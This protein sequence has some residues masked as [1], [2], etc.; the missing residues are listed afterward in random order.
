MKMNTSLA[1]AALASVIG[2][3]ALAQTD[4]FANTG[5]GTGKSAVEERNEDLADDIEDDF[6]RNVDRFGNEG[7]RLGF[8]GSLS[9][10]GLATDGNDRDYNLGIGANLGYFDGVNG[11]ELNLSYA[12]SRGEYKNEA[13]EDELQTS[14]DNLLYEF[15][16]TRDFNPDLYGFVKLQGSYNGDDEGG[17]DFVDADGDGINDNEDEAY[18]RNDV[19]LGLGIGYRIINTP[20]QQ[21]A[22]Q[23]GPGYR[24]S[25]FG[26]IDN[27]IL[28][29]DILEG[30][31]DDI[32]EAAFG[33]SSN[34]FQRINDTV[35]FTIDTDIIT[36]SADT[37]VYNDAGLN[38]AMSNRLALRTSLQTEYHTDPI[39]SRDS[40]DNRLGV[41]VVYNFN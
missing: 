3:A 18:R 33:V 35:F 19:F 30:D 4:T 17:S 41:A 31:G 36:S 25:D 37:V 20:D 39:G 22:I 2:T 34:Y 14:Q 9:A 12:F 28:S 26:N 40:T 16:Y 7:R 5:F 23:A 6:E 24:F 8:D 29:G 21:W 1:L 10:R 27:A 11:Y 32:N 15:Q 38:V 13:G